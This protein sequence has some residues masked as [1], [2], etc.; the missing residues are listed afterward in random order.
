V[1]VARFL[2]GNNFIHMHFVVGGVMNLSVRLSVGDFV[3]PA[4]E[5]ELGVAHLIAG[6]GAPVKF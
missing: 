1:V 4:R 5:F 2:P 6:L 3:H